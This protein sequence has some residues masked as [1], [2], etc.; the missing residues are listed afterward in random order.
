M[1]DE[2]SIRVTAGA[3]TDEETAAVAA[4]FTQL[5]LEQSASSAPLPEQAGA[6]DWLRS[7]RGLRQ[8]LPRGGR[9]Q[10]R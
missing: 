1:S 5:L 4:V 8:P 7:A 3:P 10:S 2:P 6:S 9:W